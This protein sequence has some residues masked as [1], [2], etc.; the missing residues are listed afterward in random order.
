MPIDYS[1][2]SSLF[3]VKSKVNGSWV[4]DPDVVDPSV[5]L[6]ATLTDSDPAVRLAWRMEYRSGSKVKVKVTFR[7]DD[8]SEAYGSF[9]VYAFIVVPLHPAEDKLNPGNV[10]RAIEMNPPSVNGTST[11]PMILDELGMN[12]VFGLRFSNISAGDTTR[13]FVRIEE[14]D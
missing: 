14:V 7:R 3:R 10:R 6:P 11:E 9:T 8:G 13:M 12:D 2:E 4:D 1:L 5:E